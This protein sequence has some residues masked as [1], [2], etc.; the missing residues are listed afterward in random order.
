M[1][2]SI[3]ECI[4]Y[5]LAITCHISREDYQ[6]ILLAVLIEL[7]FPVHTDGFVYLLEA[8]LIKRDH[9]KMRMAAVY[10]E[11]AQRSEESIN[12]TLIEQSIRRTIKMAWSRGKFDSWLYFFSEKEAGGKGPANKVFISRMAYMSELLNR[13]EKISYNSE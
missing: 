4:S 12:Y 1:E 2:H 13:C 9:P 7:G 10:E 8:I 11:I 6:A 3:D 5:V